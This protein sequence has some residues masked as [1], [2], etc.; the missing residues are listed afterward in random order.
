MKSAV[1]SIGLKIQPRLLR[2][3]QKVD[4]NK[5][6]L[7]RVCFYL[8]FPLIIPVRVKGRRFHK[9]QLNIVDF[10]EFCQ[11]IQIQISILSESVIRQRLPLRYMFR[12]FHVH[13]HIITVMRHLRRIKHVIDIRARKLAPSRMIAQNRKYIVRIVFFFRHGRKNRLM[14]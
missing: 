2:Q 9:D 8:F 3:F 1:I 11:F 12:R 10:A 7:F 13:T 6:I 5:I 4:I 14:L